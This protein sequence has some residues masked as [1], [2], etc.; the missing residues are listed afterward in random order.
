MS[1]QSEPD[2]SDGVQSTDPPLG[3]VL[4]TGWAWLVLGATVG[5]VV[6]QALMFVLPKSYT[7]DTAVIV[8]PVEVLDSVGT[9]PTGT[10]EVNLDTEAQLVQSFVVAQSAQS[11]MGTDES[12]DKLLSRV[13]VSVPPTRP[14]SISSTPPAAPRVRASERRLSPRPICSSARTAP[15]RRWPSARTR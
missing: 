8:R 14:S 2:Q 11:K 9:S 3:R 6:G 5:L 15:S 13:D 12:T 4:K 7:A 10:T 1:F